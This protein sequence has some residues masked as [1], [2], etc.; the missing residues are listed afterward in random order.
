MS[1]LVMG[2][3]INY[4]CQRSCHVGRGMLTARTDRAHSTEY[5]W[6]AIIN[7]DAQW[8]LASKRLEFFFWSKWKRLELLMAAGT[9]VTQSHDAKC[10][11]KHVLWEKVWLYDE[12]VMNK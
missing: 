10:V 9:W 2:K 8:G 1:K 11:L 12:N 5:I 7:V 6:P 3:T 4:I